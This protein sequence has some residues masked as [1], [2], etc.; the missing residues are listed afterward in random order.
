MIIEFRNTILK[1]MVKEDQKKILEWRKRKEISNVMITSIEKNTFE[2]QI[3][4]FNKIQKDKS[5]KYWVIY[6]GN[7]PVGVVNLSKINYKEKSVNWAF[8]LADLSPSLQGVGA[9]VEF[10]IINYVFFKMK[11]QKLLCQV[12]SNN[13]KVVEL[14]KK[15]GFDQYK[16]EKSKY[17]KGNKILDLHYLILTHEKVLKKNYNKINIKYRD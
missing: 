5:F 14:H 12:L 2:D 6:K 7:E 4:W 9:K 17:K 3:L 13:L 8:Y 11:Y 15:F 16:I 10:M 1:P